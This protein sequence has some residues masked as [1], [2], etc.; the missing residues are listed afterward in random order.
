MSVFAAGLNPANETLASA[1]RKVKI[2]S[3]QL[4]GDRPAGPRRLRWRSIPGTD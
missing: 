1:L 2:D 4:C 3:R